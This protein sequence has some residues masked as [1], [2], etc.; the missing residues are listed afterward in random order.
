MKKTRLFHNSQVMIFRQLEALPDMH[1]GIFA[2]RGEVL[3]VRGPGYGFD[4][5]FMATIDKSIFP[6][7]CGPDMN[8]AAGIGGGETLTIGRPGQRAKA[9]AM[10]GVDVYLVIVENIPDMYSSIAPAAG[11]ITAIRRPRQGVDDNAIFRTPFPTTVSISGAPY[12]NHPI[13]A[14]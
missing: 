8:S 5:L 14:A 6:V 9:S 2:C 1:F 11:Q 12:A 4:A 3:P 13:K 7:Q 10:P